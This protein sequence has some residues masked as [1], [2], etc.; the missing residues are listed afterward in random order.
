[1]A[2]ILQ[3]EAEDFLSLFAGSG[4]YYLQSIIQQSET[5]KVQAR[6]RVIKGKVDLLVALNHLKGT[7]NLGIIPIVKDKV[8]WA[9]LDIDQVLDLPLIAKRLE[10]LPFTVC[11]SK[12][13]HA[14]VFAF[15]KQWTKA[16]EAIA[17]IETLSAFLG[18]GNSEIFPKQRELIQGEAGNGL[19][20]PYFGGVSSLRYALNQKGEAIQTVGKFLKYSHEKLIDRIAKIKFPKVQETLPNGPPCLNR[21]LE[22]TTETSFRN[23]TLSNV[24]VYLKKRFPDSW[25]VELD[26]TNLSFSQPLE[27]REVEAIKASYEKKDYN[28]QCN[29]APLCNFCDSTTCRT[30]KYGVHYTQSLPIKRS[31]CKIDTSPPIWYLEIIVS[32]SSEKRIQLSTEEL[33]N[34]RL[35][36]KKCMEVLHQ[37]PELMPHKEWQK[38][39]TELME[40][41]S[42]VDIPEELKPE[43][44][45][46]DHI[47]SFVLEKNNQTDEDGFNAVARDLVFTDSQ[48]HYFRLNALRGY[49][50]D[51]GFDLLKLNHIIDYIKTR[52][53]GAK[54]F[55]KVGTRGIN[56]FRIPLIID[57][58]YRYTTTHE[59]TEAEPF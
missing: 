30:K 32:D 26:R 2:G 46:K 58:N 48:Y 6:Y 42:V 13:G 35:Y 31:L 36:Q 11:R 51:E 3:K 10:K 37:V 44:I 5:E 12:S 20:L 45:L 25:K 4:D 1:M 29:L 49:L 22:D 34:V 28:Y 50:R 59:E 9:C 47:E 52:L 56:M 40:H 57:V 55:K 33:Q 17:L 27:T 15:F 19:N 53:N 54:L 39:L 21:I 43:G 23:I 14:H 16:R 8:K 38:I 7:H 41:V 24:A 18:V